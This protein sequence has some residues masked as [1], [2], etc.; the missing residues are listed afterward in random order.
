M[1]ASFDALARAGSPSK[2]S[3]V[4]SAIDGP[5]YGTATSGSSFRCARVG[6][7]RSVRTSPASGAA[8]QTYSAGERRPSAPSSRMSAPGRSSPEICRRPPGSGTNVRRNGVSTSSIAAIARHGTASSRPPPRP[9]ASTRGVATIG[10]SAKPTLPPIENAL[11]P[12]ARFSPLVYAA[13]FDPSGWNAATPRPETTTSTTT[14]QYDGIA[15]AMPIP[16]P[17][18]ATPAGRSQSAPRR[19]DHSPNRGCTSDDDAVEASISSAASVYESENLSFRNGS[20]AGK[21]PLAK[22]VPR[23]PAAS[24]VLAPLWMPARHLQ[25]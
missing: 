25:R 16:T 19:S 23:C 2:N 15:A 10:P 22:S 24:A 18:R 6:G 3:R 1:P 14:S 11:I 21:A 20:S 12:L 8:A 13:N 9:S 4:V 7:R 17:A 5:Y